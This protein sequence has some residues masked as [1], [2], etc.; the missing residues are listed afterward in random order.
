MKKSN[1][2]SHSSSL[3]INILHHSKPLNETKNIDFYTTNRDIKYLFENSRHNT[4]LSLE[5]S[6]DKTNNTENESLK[7][8]MNREPSKDDKNYRIN[9]EY[10]IARN[11]LSNLNIVLNYNHPWEGKLVERNEGIIKYNHHDKDFDRNLHP[12]YRKRINIK[13]S[14]CIKQKKLIFKVLYQVNSKDSYDRNYFYHHIYG[15]I[16]SRLLKN[17]ENEWENYLS[18]CEINSKHQFINTHFKDSYSLINYYHKFHVRK[19]MKLKHIPSENF[20]INY[21]NFPI[22]KEKN[23]SYLLPKKVWDTNKFDKKLSN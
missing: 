5:C 16:E 22:S 13:K 21:K 14:N 11:Q 19:C 7:C 1:F 8:N 15:H 17:C 2:N 6:I 23:D 10:I 20:T 9:D 12:F 18:N 4:Q 3:G